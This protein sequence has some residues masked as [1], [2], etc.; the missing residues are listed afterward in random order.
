MKIS[1]KFIPDLIIFFKGDNV[2]KG[3]IISNM[4]GDENLFGCCGMYI[5]SKIDRAE[6]SII[7]VKRDTLEMSIVPWDGK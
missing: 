6:S 3:G 7:F 4:Y 1:I 2:I 5:M